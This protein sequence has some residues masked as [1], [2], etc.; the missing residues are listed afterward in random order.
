ML[1][2][3][4][5][6]EKELNRT[7]VETRG[8][9]ISDVTSEEWVAVG[10]CCVGI[11]NVTQATNPSTGVDNT[12]AIPPSHYCTVTRCCSYL[13]QISFCRGLRRASSPILRIDCHMPE[14]RSGWP[15]LCFKS[16]AVEVMRTCSSYCYILAKRTPASP[17]RLR[18]LG[19]SLAK[20]PGSV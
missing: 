10:S 14:G 7:S 2:R 9:P 13:F 11:C 17:A 16:Q 15:E 4:T 12:V 6:K 8:N 20:Q 5:A 19:G 3:G 1:I 18:T